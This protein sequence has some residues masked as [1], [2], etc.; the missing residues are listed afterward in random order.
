[1]IQLPTNRRYDLVCIGQASIDSIK[2]GLRVSK[3]LLGGAALYT[4]V[5]GSMLGLRTALVSHVAGDYYAQF[6]SFLLARKVDITGVYLKEGSSTRIALDY[7]G[8]ELKS[9]RVIEGV[10]AELTVSDV[11]EAFYSTA[12]A[13]IAPGPLQTQIQVGAMMRE[14]GVLVVFDPHADFNKRVF[15]VTSK[16]LQNV[17]I[18]FSNESEIL[19]ITGKNNSERAADKIRSAGVSIVV[20]TMGEKGAMVFSKEERLRIPPIAPTKLV[21]VVGAGDAFKAGFL[22][23]LTKGLSLGDCGVTGAAAAACVLEG[24][25]LEAA[26]TLTMLKEALRRSKIVLPNL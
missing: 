13:Y 5:T 9:V 3:N 17:G 16:V 14:R 4:A 10:G 2:N 11:P 26:P 25:G 6:R 18:F 20:V 12:M 21:D 1:M 8:Q 23:G 22:L 24:V 15:S 7:E 19:A